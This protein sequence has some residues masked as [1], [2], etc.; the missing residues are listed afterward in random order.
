MIFQTKP[1][2]YKTNLAIDN[3]AS[4]KAFNA[5]HQTSREDFH[6]IGGTDRISMKSYRHEPSFINSCDPRE[7][8]Q[9]PVLS[10]RVLG[11]RTC[12]PRYAHS[13]L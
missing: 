4:L 12:R 6:W 7:H 3:P 2:S 8:M 13:V 5:G 11:P 10:E 9:S 1:N